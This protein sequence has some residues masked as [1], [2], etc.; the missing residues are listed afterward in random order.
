[1]TSNALR[2]KDI[3]SALTDNLLSSYKHDNNTLILQEFG[4]C[5]HLV[6]VDMAVVNGIMMGFEIKSDADTLERLP[7]QSE[8]YSK[9][10]DKVIIVIGEIHITKISDKIPQWWGIWVAHKTS[11]N[12]EL[13]VYREPQKNCHIDINYLVKCLWKQEALDIIKEKGF[14]KKSLEKY[15][16]ADLW[17]LL[18][19]SLNIQELQ[20]LIRKQLK[21]RRDWRIVVT[22]V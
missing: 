4:L 2:D 3:R 16:R 13:S 5:E 9:I 21:Q 12:V 10:F 19:E 15:K 17:N 11:G 14:Y 1:M 18:S 7:V 6:R 22:Q 20:Y 8:I